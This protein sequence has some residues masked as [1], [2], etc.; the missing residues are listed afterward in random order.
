MKVLLAHKLHV[1]CCYTYPY[2]ENPENTS[3]HKWHSA[4]D[5]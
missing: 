3:K 2:D 5:Q 4:K 1:K